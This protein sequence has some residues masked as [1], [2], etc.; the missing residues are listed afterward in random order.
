MLNKDI[1]AVART[2]PGFSNIPALTLC[3]HPCPPMQETGLD[4]Y[5]IVK[6]AEALEVRFAAWGAAC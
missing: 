3:W 4:Q 6:F 1:P 5:A 2:A